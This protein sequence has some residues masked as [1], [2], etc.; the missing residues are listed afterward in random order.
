MMRPRWPKLSRSAEQAASRHRLLRQVAITLSPR[1]GCNHSDPL[2]PFIAPELGRVGALALSSERTRTR[3]TRDSGAKRNHRL[4]A[5]L[6]VQTT[7]SS[8]DSLTQ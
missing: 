5:V 3:V 8:R 4:P 7:K 6:V 2:L 1:P